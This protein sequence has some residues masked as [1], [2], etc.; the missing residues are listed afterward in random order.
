MA[1]PKPMTG[2]IDGVLHRD[3]MRRAAV[4]LRS[5]ADA[6]EQL[7]PGDGVL[8]VLSNAALSLLC[9]AD[10]NARAGGSDR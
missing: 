7:P 3:V 2:A 6:L 4:V 8:A 10:A 1:D 5:T 9:A